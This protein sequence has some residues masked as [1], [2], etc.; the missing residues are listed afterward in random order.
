MPAAIAYKKIG[1]AAPTDFGQAHPSQPSIEIHRNGL[2]RVNHLI[3][4]SVGHR[5]LG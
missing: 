3:N 4:Q 2:R 1:R 5:L